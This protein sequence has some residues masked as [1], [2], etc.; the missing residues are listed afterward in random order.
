MLLSSLFQNGIH[1]SSAAPHGPAQRLLHS[2]AGLVSLPALSA[3]PGLCAVRGKGF[4][5]QARCSLRSAEP[6]RIA[7]QGTDVRAN[8]FI[9]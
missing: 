4:L 5:L 9:T 1:V 6:S 2:P 7:P 3:P 8:P